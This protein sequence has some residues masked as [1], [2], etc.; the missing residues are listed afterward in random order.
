MTEASFESVGLP[1]AVGAVEAAAALGL[2]A[3]SARRDELVPIIRLANELYYG[4][5]DSVIGLAEARFS[6]LM[7][8]VMQMPLHHHRRVTDDG[9]EG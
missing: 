6:E 4:A 1:V 5:G 9:L 3:A 8:Y 7:E 2:E